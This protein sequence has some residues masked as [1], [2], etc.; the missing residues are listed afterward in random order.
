MESYKWN[1]RDEEVLNEDRLWAFMYILLYPSVQVFDDS[2]SDSVCYIT[3][4][5][6]AS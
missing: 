2:V 3:K 6:R 5:K 4:V 1:E